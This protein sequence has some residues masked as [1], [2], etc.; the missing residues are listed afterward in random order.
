M[1]SLLRVAIPDLPHHVTQRGNARQLIISH[2]SDRATYLELLRRYCELYNVALLGYCLMSNQAAVGRRTL[3]RLS[4]H[5][6]VRHSCFQ[7]TW[8][9]DPSVVKAVGVA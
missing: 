2:H 5:D 9:L 7:F 6:V 4:P 8:K 1:A 3:R